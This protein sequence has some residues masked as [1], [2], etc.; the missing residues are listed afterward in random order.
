MTG[1]K[2]TPG[3][4]TRCDDDRKVALLTA[5]ALALALDTSR[6]IADASADLARF[7]SGDEAGLEDAADQVHAIAAEHPGPDAARAR[8]IVDGAV[9]RVASLNRHPSSGHPATVRAAS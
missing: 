4:A 5:R 3:P 7:S 2:G 9:R 8:L 1:P 6:G